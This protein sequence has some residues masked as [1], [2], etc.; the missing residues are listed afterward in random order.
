MYWIGR[1][2]AS[3]WMAGA[4]VDFE[5]VQPGNPEEDLGEIAAFA[6]MYRPENT[7]WKQQLVKYWLSI[8][9]ELF[10]VEMEA[11]TREMLRE[12]EFMKIRRTSAEV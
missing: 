7:P 1:Q 2:S 12:L 3:T 4:A 8:S 11:L 6:L 10:N 9:A 5:D